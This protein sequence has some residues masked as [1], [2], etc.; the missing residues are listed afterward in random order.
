MPPKI[1]VPV[2]KEKNC[3]RVLTSSENLRQI[4]QQ[5]KEKKEKE[6]SRKKRQKKVGKKSTEVRE[7]LTPLQVP[8][9][10]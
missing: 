2:A 5:E 9:R 7:T 10:K 4:E 6:L 1:Q 8:T 3:S